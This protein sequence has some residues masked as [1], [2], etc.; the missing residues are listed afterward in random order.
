MLESH[1][2]TQVPIVRFDPA[3]LTIRGQANS[4]TPIKILRVYVIDIQQNVIVEKCL[5]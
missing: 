5:V 1:F 3:D 2:S 4:K